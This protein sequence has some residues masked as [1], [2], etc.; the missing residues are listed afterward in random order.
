MNHSLLQAM[1]V[2]HPALEKAVQITK[3]HGLDCKLTGAGGGGCALALIPPNTTDQELEA[4]R[5]ELMEAGLD[6]FQADVG[7][8]G[9]QSVCAPKDKKTEIKEA[10]LSKGNSKD[11]FKSEAFRSLFAQ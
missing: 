5:V 6:A 7:C 9:V 8:S 1:G 2:S 11:A 3:A 10:L 4:V